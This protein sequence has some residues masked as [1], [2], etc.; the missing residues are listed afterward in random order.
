MYIHIIYLILGIQRI[1]PNVGWTGW[2]IKIVYNVTHV[3]I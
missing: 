3:I 1:F 2:A